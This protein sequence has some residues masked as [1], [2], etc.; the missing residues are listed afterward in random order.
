M[1]SFQRTTLIADLCNITLNI[2]NKN[3]IFD[4]VL[5]VNNPMRSCS[6]TN[7]TELAHRIEYLFNHYNIIR[8]YIKFSVEHR[9]V[10]MLPSKVNGVIAKRLR[11]DELGP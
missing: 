8:R 2:E 6:V 4:Y 11:G 7:D 1:V 10:L 9:D 5:L 3:Q